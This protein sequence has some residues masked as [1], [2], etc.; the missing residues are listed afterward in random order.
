MARTKAFDQSAVLDK[1]MRVF[2]AK[3]YEATSLQD[4]VDGM[5][6]NRQSLY[7]TYGDKHALYL[8]ALDRYAK[9][10]G[11]VAIQ[12]LIGI[13]HKPGAVRAA[14]RQ[15]L[16]NVV[17]EE[18]CDGQGKGCLIANAALE[19]ANRDDDVKQRVAAAAAGTER[20]FR[21]ALDLGQARGEFAASLDTLAGARF[22]ANTV[23]GLRVMSKTSGSRQALQDVL[24]MALK[25]L[26]VP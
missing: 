12:P 17:D 2:W 21:A 4:L 14:I 18:L 25:I 19:S 3:G 16:Q 7:D 20:V 5:G 8:A 23:S 22:L 15:A 1:A 13:E 6:I 11:P 26:D 10:V 24:A 9:T